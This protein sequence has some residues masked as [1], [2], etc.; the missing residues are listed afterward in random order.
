MG[1]ECPPPPSPHRHAWHG[2][3]TTSDARCRRHAAHATSPAPAAPTHPHAAPRR[4]ATGLA[5]L[6]W[7]GHYTCLSAPTPSTPLLRSA[8]A[9]PSRQRSPSSAPREYGGD[10]CSTT[11]RFARSGHI[12]PLV[13]R[14]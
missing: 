3:H 13:S 4:R 10:G 8:D 2:L 12:A 1:Q 11:P 14:R 9:A 7:T 6:P 5:P